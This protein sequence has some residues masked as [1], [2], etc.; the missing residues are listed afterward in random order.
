MG[1]ARGSLSV[2]LLCLLIVHNTSAATRC[3]HRLRAGSGRFTSPGYPGLYD[4]LQSC[5]WIIIAERSHHVTLEFE[6]F[7]LESS[8]SCRFDYVEIRDG[9]HGASNLIDRY[10]GGDK[11]PTITSSGHLLYVK[12]VS[13]QSEERTGFAASYESGCSRT[14]RGRSGA[15][16]SPNY[17]GNYLSNQNCTYQIIAPENHIIHLNFAIFSMEGKDT[18]DQCNYDFV[19]IHERQG[20]AWEFMDRFCGPARPQSVTSHSNE[21]KVRFQSDT[22]INNQGFVAEFSSEARAVNPCEDD[23]N[24]G[25]EHRCDFIDET[26]SCSCFDGF[27]LQRDYVSCGDIDECRTDE[28][29]CDQ[30]CINTVGSYQCS[31]LDGYYLSSDGKSCNDKNECLE[32]GRGGCSDVCINTEGSYRCDCFSAQYELSVDGRTCVVPMRSG[33]DDDNGGCGHLCHPIGREGHYCTCHAGFK[34]SKDRHACEDINECERPAGQFNMFSHNCNQICINNPGSYYC[35]C[36]QGFQLSPNGKVCKDIDEC[37]TSLRHDCSQVCINMAGSYEC[38]CNDGHVV[39]PED[40]NSCLDIDECA[41]PTT[42]CHTCVNTEGSF[43]CECR[44]GFLLDVNGTSCVD[45]NECDRDNGGCQHVC[46]NL[47]GSHECKCRSGYRIDVGNNSLCQ[48]INECASNDGKGPCSY[49]CINSE[50]SFECSCER[51]YY[52]REDRLTCEDINECSVENGGCQQQCVNL[53]GNYQCRCFD[54]FERTDPE[55]D[56]CT[57]IDEC[58]EGYDECAVSEG[59]VC[60]NTDGNYTCQCPEGYET[61]DWFNCRDINECHNDTTS[62]CQQICHNIEGSFNCSCYRGYQQVDEFSCED[63]DECL[64]IADCDHECIN[65][66]GGYECGCRDGFSLV[67]D[68]ACTDVNECAVN[69]GGCDHTCINDRGGHRCDCQEGYHLALDNRACIDNNE[70]TLGLALCNQPHN[71]M[72]LNGSYTCS[73]DSGYYMD[74]DN[75]TCLDIDECALNTDGCDHNCQNTPGGFNC[76]CNDGYLLDPEDSKT[77]IDINECLTNNGGCSHMCKNSAG[78]YQCDCLSNYR[79]SADKQT[80]KACPSCEDFEEMDMAMYTMQQTVTDLQ[81]MVQALVSQNSELQ[82]RIESLENFQNTYLTQNTV[83]PV[84]R[85]DIGVDVNVN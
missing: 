31:C 67:S 13:D 14:L 74:P 27:A 17:P 47:Q 37:A 80:C 18:H 85:G 36:Q 20:R 7:S 25:C 72:N 66:D 68:S 3:R 5:E 79:L 52:L 73:C 50:G 84:R 51:G 65:T 39:D 28:N 45:I 4:R 29:K 64:S 71:C 43:Q 23:D 42:D 63:I 56:E 44:Q 78:S 58:A 12:F 21:L 38:R 9:G 40:S 59:A 82:N 34:L 35:D 41:L 19:E 6:T 11:P 54:G 62:P 77:C 2:L 60:I 32:Y 83:Q 8:S 1:A 10:C 53:P 22:S 75:H 57:D 70:C 61:F 15:F 55:V 76:T 30:I 16:N 46:A 48:D 24:G 26:V 69:N 81:Q 33:C 49:S